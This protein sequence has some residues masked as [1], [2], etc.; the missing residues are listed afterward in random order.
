MRDIVDVVGLKPLLDEAGIADG[1]DDF[2]ALYSDLITKGK[3]RDLVTRIED[4]IVTYFSDLELPDEPTLYDHLVLSLR[5]KDYIATFNWDPFLWQ[6]LARNWR[7]GTLPTPIF[8]HGNA[9]FGCC[10]EHDQ[11]VVRPRGQLCPRCKRPMP[12]PKL[13]FPVRQKNYSSDRF[14]SK[15]W[16]TLR[17]ALR[18]AFLVTIFGYSAPVT[19]VEAI[20]LLKS[21]W[22]DPVQ[23]SLEE[24]EIIDIKDEWELFR[25]WKP[26]FHSHHYQV[27]RSFYESIVGRS[28]RRSVEA[29]FG[30]MIDLN[31]VAANPIPRTSDWNEVNLFFGVLC[32][33]ELSSL[34]QESQ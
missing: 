20:A 32:D 13:L 5:E 30:A 10:L 29:M 2:E 21:A 28:P 11:I 12:A 27:S 8:L 14:V 26:F 9:A 1:R 22:G 18:E 34:A 3:Y 24:I 31:P 6:A 7:P 23:R 15:S 19:D 16:E 17:H 25:T 33:D 4:A